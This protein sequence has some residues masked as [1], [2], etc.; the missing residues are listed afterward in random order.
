M[1]GHLSLEG[2][3]ACLNVNLHPLTEP[4]A[5]PSHYPLTIPTN[6]SVGQCA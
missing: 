1:D 5:L 6:T 3:L 2:S 4:L